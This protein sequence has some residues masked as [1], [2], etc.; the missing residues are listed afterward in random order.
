MSISVEQEM[1]VFQKVL[2]R[3]LWIISGIAG[4]NLDLLCIRQ[5]DAAPF[6]ENYANT[7]FQ[8][9]HKDT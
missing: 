7:Y 8:A 2:S 6:I 9:K 4:P 3:P 5:P 1:I